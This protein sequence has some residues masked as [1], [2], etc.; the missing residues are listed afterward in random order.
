VLGI[1]KAL[2]ICCRAGKRADRW[3]H[4]AQRRAAVRRSALTRMLAGNVG[5][6]YV[7]RQYLDARSAVAERGARRQT[8]R[9]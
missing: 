2:Q 4:D 9:R 1:Y 7:V 3:I 6:L 8:C 5:D